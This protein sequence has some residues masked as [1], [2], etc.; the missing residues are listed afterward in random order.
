MS[1]GMMWMSGEMAV[2]KAAFWEKK[3]KKPHAFA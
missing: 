1:V 3:T 2:D